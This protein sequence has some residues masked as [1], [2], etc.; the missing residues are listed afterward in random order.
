MLAVNVVDTQGVL[1][2]ADGFGDQQQHCRTDLLLH[3]LL[4]DLLFN[5]F[6]LLLNR[7]KDQIVGSLTFHLASCHSVAMIPRH[8][9]VLGMDTFACQGVGGRVR[10]GDRAR[11]AALT[12]SSSFEA[13]GPSTASISFSSCVA[14]SFTSASVLRHHRA[15]HR[16]IRA[17]RSL[18][19]DLL[20]VFIM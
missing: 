20:L 8:G 19:L 17:L 1:R 6:N 12:S 2:E 5:L 4:L 7:G 3:N 13:G 9:E 16:N 14:S 15:P 18:P 11:P 10:P